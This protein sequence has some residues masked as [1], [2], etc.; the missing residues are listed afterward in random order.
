MLIF[1][2]EIINNN[3]FSFQR[4]IFAFFKQYFFFFSDR[5][6]LISFG[7]SFGIMSWLI[8]YVTCS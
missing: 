2:L 5:E 8:P 6:K 7:I 3:R 4:I 1:P